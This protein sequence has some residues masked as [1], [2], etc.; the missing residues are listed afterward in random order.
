M[1]AF[2]CTGVWWLPA[3]EKDRLVGTLYVSDTG[4]LN[5]KVVGTLSAAGLSATNNIPVI[6]GAVTDCPLGTK[7]SL[8][9]LFRRSHTSGS[10]GVEREGYYAHLAYFG[11]HLDDESDF[12]FQSVR[13]KL[14][15]L[16]EW[17]HHLSGFADQSVWGG[18]G[19]NVPLLHYVMPTSP[20][21]D[22]P[23]G[24]ILL[25]FGMSSSSGLG[26][27]VFREEV[28]LS[29]SLNAAATLYEIND[30]YVYPLQNFL[31]LAS[32]SAQ[33]V[34]SL[35]VGRGVLAWPSGIHVI[36]ERIQPNVNPE[37]TKPVHYI[38]MLFTLQD[39]GERFPVVMGRWLEMADKYSAAFAIYFGIQYA[40]LAY[41]DFTFLG[42]V[43]SIALYFMRRQD[44]QAMRAEEGC[45]L[46]A[47]LAKLSEAETDWL[48]KH[49]GDSPFPPFEDILGVLLQEHGAELDPLISGRRQEFIN[50]VL[51]MLRYAIHRESTAI[52]AAK[53]GSEL[54]SLTET[55]RFVM[56]ACLLREM[57]FT[58]QERVA[59]FG[60]N[61][62]YDYLRGLEVARRRE[63]H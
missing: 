50:E 59:L 31:T 15:G 34:T 23:S 30:R 21:A 9:R 8:T 17:S 54:Y 6:L 39:L 28:S 43:Q 60:R 40:P 12:R 22:V 61:R 46:K 2:D 33:E 29:L 26:E 53:V 3:G 52:A 19:E 55:L 56:K 41:L 14:S 51:T 11:D 24:Q 16:A 5:L 47:V 32:D 18:V 7:I 37:D 10:S 25:G 36:G 27:R 20:R 45:R 1:K 35:S 63:T 57:G 62:I 49:L 4:Q 44:G 38:H 13:L 58:D 42:V 48:L